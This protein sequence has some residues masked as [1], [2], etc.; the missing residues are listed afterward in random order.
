MVNGVPK[1]NFVMV[2]HVSSLGVPPTQASNR[3]Q[4]CTD[5]LFFFFLKKSIEEIKQNAMCNFQ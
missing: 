5:P 2:P 4:G 3:R 1:L